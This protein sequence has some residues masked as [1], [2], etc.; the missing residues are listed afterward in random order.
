LVPNDP[1]IWR[2]IR[3]IQTDMHNTKYIYK[4]MMALSTVK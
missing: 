1:A 2:T 4:I 3:N